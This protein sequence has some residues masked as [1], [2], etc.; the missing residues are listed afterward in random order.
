[1]LELVIAAGMNSEPLEEIIVTGNRVGQSREEVAASVSTLT[2]DQ[3]RLTPSVTIDTLLNQAPG[4][5][6]QNT[7]GQQHLTSIRSPV[8]TAGAGQGSFLYLE[9]GLALRAAAFGNVNGGNHPDA[10]H[11]AVHQLNRLPSRCPGLACVDPGAMLTD[12]NHFQQIRVQ[13]GL[14]DRPLKM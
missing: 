12:I 2:G 10:R 8:L 3:L 5:M 6:L 13:S 11:P 1:M 14:S 7:N 9:N 4:V